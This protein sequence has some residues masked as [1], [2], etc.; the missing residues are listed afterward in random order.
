MVPPVDF[1][2]QSSAELKAL[3]AELL[4][5]VAALTAENAALR[6]E[7]A[8]LKGLKGRPAI[9]PSGME[10]ST[11]SKPLQRKAQRRRGRGGQAR[12][13]VEDRVI[14]AAV[15]AGSRFKSLPRRRPG[16]TRSMWFRIWRSGRGRSATVASAG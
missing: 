12:V 11:S 13:A 2:G 15:P 8:R 10:Q 16:A 14:A 5:K 3:I 1:E 9:K 7:I 4:A 6:E